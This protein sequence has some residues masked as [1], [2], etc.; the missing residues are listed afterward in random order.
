M[1]L[2]ADTQALVWYVTD[3]DRLSEHAVAALQTSSDAEEAVG[4]S[5]FSLVELAYA[6]EK[7]SNAIS[8]EQATE[9]LAVLHDPES[10][11]EVLPVDLAVGER[12]REV[13]RT[14][15]ADPGDRIVVA[16][17]EVHGLAVI[18]SDSKMAEMTEQEIIW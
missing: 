12:V 16:T 10:P 11:F 5:G 1:R 18:S 15:N 17:A 3:P 14:I 2:L 9:I 8:E 6:V 13:P 7:K 4:V